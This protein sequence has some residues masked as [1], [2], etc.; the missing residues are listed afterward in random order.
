MCVPRLQDGPP[1]IS[2]GRQGAQRAR[3]FPRPQKTRGQ[4][5]TACRF[6]CSK[7][8]ADAGACYTQV[9]GTAASKKT[10]IRSTVAVNSVLVAPL[11]AGLATGL[12]QADIL[13]TVAV[14]ALSCAAST[15]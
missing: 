7:Q 15:I 14:G 5:V 13:I 1:R 9:M 6:D 3:S 10:G 4:M 8:P 11:I 2:A 12:S